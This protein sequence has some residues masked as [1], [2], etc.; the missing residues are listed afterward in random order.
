MPASML[1][2]LPAQLQLANSG[3]SPLGGGF[4]RSVRGIRQACG[5]SGGPIMAPAHR[6]GRHQSAAWLPARRKQLK[7]SPG[8][9]EGASMLPALRNCPQSAAWPQVSRTQPRTRAGHSE[10]AKRLP[11]Q[12]KQSRAGAVS[13]ATLTL[14]KALP[15]ED[16]R[17]SPLTPAQF[18]P[19][20]NRSIGSI[21]RLLHIM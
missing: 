6:A 3:D 18:M 14:R 1:Q 17:C 2:V 21:L 9:L 16:P 5:A 8:D 19:G 13:R 7:A 4:L 12:G 15:E 20:M 10:G 11:G